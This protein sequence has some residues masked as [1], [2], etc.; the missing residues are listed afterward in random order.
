MVSPRAAPERH[1]AEES[2]GFNAA[3][4][5]P[6]EISPKRGVPI[7]FE[8]DPSAESDAHD[9]GRDESKQEGESGPVLPEEPCGTQRGHSVGREL[10]RMDLVIQEA[11]V[12]IH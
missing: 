11:F 1:E 9:R 5:V 10:Q 8:I 12:E 3:T 6:T 2:R 4:H 7:P